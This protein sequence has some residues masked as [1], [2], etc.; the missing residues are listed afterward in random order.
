[1]KIV[2]DRIVRCT[3]TARVLV[4]AYD[5]YQSFAGYAEVRVNAV[6]KKGDVDGSDTVDTMDIEYLINHLLRFGPEPTPIE[7]G[8]INGDGLINIADLTNIIDLLLIKNMDPICIETMIPT[9]TL[10]YYDI[11]YTN[12][13]TDLK[14]ITSKP[15]KGIQIGLKTM[16]MASP[17]NLLGDS[18]NF[19]Y[20]IS[21]SIIKIGILDSNGI[22]TI[23]PGIYDILKIP[24]RIIV[25]DIIV[26]D[27]AHQAHRGF[28]STTDVLKNEEI[29]PTVY[30]L[31]QSYP[32]PFNPT[33]TIEFSIPER[34]TVNLRVY[35]ILGQEIAVLSSQQLY[36]PGYHEV[37]FDC[38]NCAS[39]LYFYRLEAA[40]VS[41]PSRTFIQVKK[42]I[43]LK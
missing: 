43:L 34:S 12:D 38:T 31:F 41:D 35:N 42:M 11:S 33:A 22:I 20:G 5:K 9:D 1:V 39:G 37:T 28:S 4:H 13:T 21:D 26:S 16:S 32:N 19:I 3:D 30:K 36:N 2:H 29:V 7:T 17:I 25:N 40:S 8:D 10:V 14:L 24:G 6:G 15:L 18:L 27:T 23:T